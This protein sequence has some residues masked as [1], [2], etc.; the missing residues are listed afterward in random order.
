MLSVGSE[1]K[2]LLPAA[3]ENLMTRLTGG[4]GSPEGLVKT[5]TRR[6]TGPLRDWRKSEP[7]VP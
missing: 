5:W 3:V 7:V 4:L 2:V 6:P 1:D